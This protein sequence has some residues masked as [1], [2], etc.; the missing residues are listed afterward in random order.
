[1]HAFI[2]L[3]RPDAEEKLECVAEVIAIV[4]VER[5]GAVVDGELG[6][7]AD[8]YPL[9]VRHVADVTERVSAHWE[10]FR[11][12]ERLEDEFVPG[13]LNTFQAKANCVSETLVS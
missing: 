12:I 4:A 9:A 1:M 6:A 8:I 5:I 11:F 10:D 7:K 3:G 13:F 2:V